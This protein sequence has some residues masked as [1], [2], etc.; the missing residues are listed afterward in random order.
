MTNIKTA[1]MTMTFDQS[2]RLGAAWRGCA[3][4]VLLLV[5]TWATAAEQKTF[6]TPEAA[7]VALTEALTADD[8]AAILGLFGEKYQSLVVSQDKAQNSVTR[9]KILSAI[10][11]FLVIEDKG[12]DTR[13][14]VIGDQAWPMPIPLVRE[15]GVWR[16]ATEQG[17]DELI[18]RRI[19][20]NER[21]ALVVLR[22][23]VD[24]QK[25]Y[26]SIDRNGDGVLEYAQKI[27]STPG[28]HDGL[29]WPEDASKGEE[30]SP[31]GPLIAESEAYAYLKGRK[32]GDP[33]RGYY[34]R[35]VTRQ[36]KS[37]PGGA[38]SYLINGHMIAGFAMVAIPAE[39]GVTGV[40][41]FI[42][43]NNGQIYEKNLGPKAAQVTEFN[44]DATWKKIEGGF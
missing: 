39:Y 44:P 24:A 27:G 40:M 22:A 20:G 11:L 3:L 12:A 10:K 31:F 15:K 37:A 14:L 2:S 13:I 7:V 35:I 1:N 32:V 41:T 8:D 9:A 6:A 16:F 25:Q 4:A 17:V 23:Y 29:Y 28:K 30:A 38:F 34:F 42:V 26:A 19:G 18:N 5:S 33:F 43:G 21:N 36:G